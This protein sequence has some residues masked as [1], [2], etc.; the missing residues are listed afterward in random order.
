MCFYQEQREP[1]RAGQQHDG[2][3]AFAAT[4]YSFLSCSS[5]QP[6]PAF[7]SSVSCSG[8][9]PARPTR[10][11]H[12]RVSALADH[13]AL[14][15][16]GGPAGVPDDGQ[17]TRRPWCYLEYRTVRADELLESLRARRPVAPML[18]S[19]SY[20]KPVPPLGATGSKPASSPARPRPRSSCTPKSERITRSTTSAFTAPIP[21]LCTWCRSTTSAR[22]L[23]RTCAS[24]QPRTTRR[25]PCAGRCTMRSLPSRSDADA[26][27][28][29]CGA[30]PASSMRGLS[31]GVGEGLWRSW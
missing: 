28:C 17:V 16:A 26:K 13:R 21:T 20:L 8:Q 27:L 5:S 10:R 6:G 14:R 31:N 15:Q 1:V 9:H 30:G 18:T 12:P 24:S 3:L 4:A 2:S 22:T 25:R 7:R 29:V 23:R 19:P 11:P